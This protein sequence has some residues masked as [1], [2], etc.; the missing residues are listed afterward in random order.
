[1]SAMSSAKADRCWSSS[2]TPRPHS[3]HG[4][5]PPIAGAPGPAAARHPL[6]RQGLRH[7]QPEAPLTSTRTRPVP[8]QPLCR[9]TWRLA[10]HELVHSISRR[11]GGA[12]KFCHSCLARYASAALH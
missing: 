4:R 8:G 3:R 7:W 2:S 1:M 9:P 6:E 12:G 10:S 11:P 5:G